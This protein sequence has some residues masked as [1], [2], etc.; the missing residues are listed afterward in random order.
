[1]NGSQQ[2]KDAAAQKPA[3]TIGATAT[4]GNSSINKKRKKEG[5]K[6]IITTEGPG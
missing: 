6:P 3:I 1:M 4:N 5:L 2:T